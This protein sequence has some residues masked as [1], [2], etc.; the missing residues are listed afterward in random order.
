MSAWAAALVFGVSLAGATPAFSQAGAP[1]P[2][3]RVQ[4]LRPPPVRLV[5]WVGPAIGDFCALPGPSEAGAPCS[6]QGTGG[7]RAGRAALR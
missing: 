6:C 4:P 5:C 3:L 1:D 7:I 2:G